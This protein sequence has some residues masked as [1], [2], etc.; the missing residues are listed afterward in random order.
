MAHS[1]CAQS[2]QLKIYHIDVDQGGS[3]LFITPNGSTLLVDAGK[4]GHGPRIKKILQQEG[5]TRVDYFVNTHY[6]E[7]HFGGIDEVENDPAIAVGTVYDRGDKQF[8]PAAKRTEGTYKDYFAAVGN[9]AIT[10]TTGMQIPIDPALSVTCISRAGLTTGDTGPTDADEENDMSL[11]LL[12]TFGNFRY[13]VGGDIEAQTEVRIANKDLVMDVDMYVADHHGS[14]SSSLLAF[15]Q[16]MVPTV[17]VISNGSTDK[18]YHPRQVT[19]DTYSHLSPPCHVFQTNKY[20][21]HKAGG[22]NVSDDF[23]A[24]LDT[25]GDEGTI[26]VVVNLTQNNYVLSYR[27]KTHTFNIKPRPQSSHPAQAI[28][29]EKIMADPAGSDSMEEYVVIKNKTGSAVNLNGWKLND[30]SSRIWP[31]DGLGTLQSN[32]SL[33][34]KRN[35]MAMTLNND[36]DLIELIDPT[37]AVIDEFRYTGSAVGVEVVTGH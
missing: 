34:V 6:H 20:L 15:M 1:H 18:Y 21:G 3:T 2:Q 35:G 28:V 36:G 37:N 13:F 12:I 19:L 17:V 32:A 11:S 27:D 31:L 22:G 23:I 10:L 5:K 4:N 26:K 14:H 30:A 8:L 16:D 33:K 25:E 29:I 9:R 24:D 7:D